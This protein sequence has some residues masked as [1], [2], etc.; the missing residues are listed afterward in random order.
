MPT[1][2]ETFEIRELVNAVHRRV[3]ESVHL[4]EINGVP[5]GVEPILIESAFPSISRTD[6]HEVILTIWFGNVMVEMC[7]LVGVE[8][9]V[10]FR[11]V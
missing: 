3:Q 9:V 8:V 7:F 11:S 2:T 1:S 5:V 4:K 6:D 10:E